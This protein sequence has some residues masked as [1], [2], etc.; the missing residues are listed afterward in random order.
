MTDLNVQPGIVVS[1]EDHGERGS[2]AR[3]VVDNRARLNVLDSSLIARLTAG[4]NSLRDDSRL[5]LLI[6]SGEGERAFIGGADI[7]EMAGL[8]ADS[9]REFITS[10]H[11]AC[12]ALRNLPV[13]V[14]A[15]ISGY[16][17]GAGLEIAAS[18]DLRVAADHS[19]FAMP[20]VRVG[21]PSVIEAALLP[22]LTGWGKAAELIY[23]GEALTA[24]KAFECGLVERVVPLEQLDQAVSNWTEAILQAGPRAIRLQKALLAEW[25]RLPL[26]EAISRGIESFAEAYRTDEPRMFMER[27]LA[28]KRGNPGAT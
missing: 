4:V 14:I 5:R 16:C 1:N 28:R 23:T 21:L 17:L 19:V 6:L 20:E 3:I 2:I 13:P 27:F 12:A 11:G 24:Q 18:C 7:R 9:A 25:A 8:D 26:D 10:L 15:R 22:R